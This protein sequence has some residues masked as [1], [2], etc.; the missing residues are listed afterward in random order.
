M[1][2]G[3]RKPKGKE[4]PQG[5]AASTAS[6]TTGTRS[7]EQ[8]ASKRAPPAGH[9]KKK[10]TPKDAEAQHAFAV[11][12]KRNKNRKDAHAIARPTV[13]PQGTTTNE[14]AQERRKTTWKISNNKD[15]D[16]NWKQQPRKRNTN[17]ATR[18]KQQREPRLAKGDQKPIRP[19]EVPTRIEKVSRLGWIVPSVNL[20]FYF[21]N[22]RRE[23]KEK[24]EATRRNDV[25]PNRG[26]H[27]KPRLMSGCLSE[28]CKRAGG[29]KGR[30]KEANLQR[31]S[32]KYGLT[33]ILST[34]AQERLKQR[35]KRTVH[36]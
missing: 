15:R 3:K 10:S 25:L 13:K 16:R 2:R 33:P 5:E 30:R 20:Y 32:R 21:P 22:P 9:P 26:V 6:N 23:R 36:S 7:K 8:K 28:K 24:K 14:V 11:K 4:T 35:G 18:E 27:H 19:Q 31:L 1:A 34:H 17:K 12:K 29:R